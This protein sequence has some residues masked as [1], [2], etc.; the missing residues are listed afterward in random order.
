M[1]QIRASFKVI[2]R[3]YKR[4][5]KGNVRLTQSSLQL[6]QF[7]SA[8]QDSYRFPVLESEPLAAPAGFVD[9]EIRLNINDEFIAY[10]IGYYVRGQLAE[11][12]ILG[13]NLM[14]YEP[15]EL[16]SSFQQLAGAWEGSLAIAVNKIT[17]L[18]K[19]DMTKHRVVQRTQYVNAAPAAGIFS[20]AQP[21]IDLSKD[22]TIPMQPMLTLSGAKKNDI[23]LSLDA[24]IAPTSSGAW[25]NAA[26]AVVTVTATQLMLIFRGM[27][28]QNAASFQGRAN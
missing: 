19:W 18:E 7:I 10:D 8:A 4:L 9:S 17:R 20:A 14:T 5:G 28:A 2:K 25:T 15:S 22:G 3:K 1:K 26:G 16:N 11:G 13:N 6:I 21:S 12:V 24:A 27:L 23:V